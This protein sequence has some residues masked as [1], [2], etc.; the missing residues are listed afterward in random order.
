MLAFPVRIVV[1]LRPSHETCRSQL[2][3]LPPY[4]AGYRL[5]L[6]KERDVGRIKTGKNEDSGKSLAILQ[7][8]IGMSK[9]FSVTDQIARYPRY[10]FTE[11]CSD[12]PV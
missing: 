10:H 8:P 5:R 11:Y 7:I 6:L 4:R 3:Q 9:R 1:V 2:E 12:N